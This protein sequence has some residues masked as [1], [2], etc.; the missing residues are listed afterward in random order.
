ML[1]EGC[2]V[3]LQKHRP[4]LPNPPGEG[5]VSVSRHVFGHNSYFALAKKAGMSRG[6]E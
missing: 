2:A 4:T 5:E 6:H 3:A 1:K